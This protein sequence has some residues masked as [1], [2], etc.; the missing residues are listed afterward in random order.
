MK[1]AVV[2]PL[3]AN[4][5]RLPNKNFLMLAHKPLYRWALD[6]LVALQYQCDIDVY[7]YC[8]NN[9]WTLINTEVK[10]LGVT[11]IIEDTASSRTDSNGFFQDIASN[12]RNYQGIMYANVTSPFVKLSTY[13]HCISIYKQDNQ[14]DSVVTA[15]PIYG[16]VWNSDAQALNH[17]PTTCPRTQSQEPVWI[18]SDAL[19][20]LDIEM[21]LRFS[22]RIGIHPYF[23]TVDLMEQHDINTVADFHMA[24]TLV[25]ST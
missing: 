11:Q 6:K 4:S 9:T 18:E 14:F 24:E 16:R 21:M 2:V 22:R 20:I 17:N 19:W 7:I 12:L 8:D 15:I 23:H 13:K 10:N 25:G 1:L 3:K 5:E